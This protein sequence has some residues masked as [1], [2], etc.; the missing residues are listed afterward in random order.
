MHLK[1]DYEE[2]LECSLRLFLEWMLEEFDIQFETGSGEHPDPKNCATN[3]IE[4][5]GA[6]MHDLT[7]SMEDEAT[8][9]YLNDR[10]AELREKYPSY[11]D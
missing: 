2:E 11:L 1:V 3:L 6:C 4:Y 8:F 10:I 9:D 5:I 7:F